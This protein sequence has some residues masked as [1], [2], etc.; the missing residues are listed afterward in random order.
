MVTSVTQ[1]YANTLE[2]Q[3]EAESS[4][5]ILLCS[6]NT[7]AIRGSMCFV[8]SHSREVHHVHSDQPQQWI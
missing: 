3:T 5:D 8:Y 7:T 6:K 2:A 4:V 1:M